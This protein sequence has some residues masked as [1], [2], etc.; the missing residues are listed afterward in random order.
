MSR[1]TLALALTL[2]AVLIAL[3]AL[4]WLDRPREPRVVAEGEP[5]P[6]GEKVEMRFGDETWKLEKRETT[7]EEAI[8]PIQMPE[9][10]LAAAAHPPS[11]SARALDA[12]GLE[13]W[14]HGDLAVAL[15]TLQKAVE[16]DPDDAVPRSHLGRL[17]TL[18][19]ANAEA[20]PH[21]ER[22]AQL[23]PDDPQVWLD[24]QSLYERS[25]RLDG[26]FEARRR[27]EALAGDRAIVQNEQG[28]YQLED[29]PSIP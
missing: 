12:A 27:A 2:S 13:A 20:L 15:D 18:M 9:P 6:Y 8:H 16:A 10:D 1:R 7:R 22:A 3:G 5:L 24:L 26:A 19:A 17:L 23:T 14:K 11:D 25:E 4:L 28:L 21:L 29:T